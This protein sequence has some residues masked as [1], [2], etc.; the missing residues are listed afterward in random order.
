VARRDCSGATAGFLGFSRRFEIR[1][2]TLQENSTVQR[3]SR[4]ARLVIGP[5]A[6][7]LAAVLVSALSVSACS[8]QGEGERCDIRGDN[9]GNDECQDGLTCRLVTTTNAAEQSYRCCPL[10]QTAP[11]VA[12]CKIAQNTVPT[13]EAGLPTTTD[14]GGDAAPVEASTDANVTD[15]SDASTTTDAPVSDAGDSGG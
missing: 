7:A 4:F 1:A 11:T 15:A 3:R 14:A 9:A 8:N 10:D 12:E 13:P 6:A 2:L 5:L